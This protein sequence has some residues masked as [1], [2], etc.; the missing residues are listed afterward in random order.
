MKL[1]EKLR[2][3]KVLK[4]NRCRYCL[5]TENLTIDHKIPVIKGGTNDIKN[6]QCLCKRCN[7]IKGQLSQKQIMFLFRWFREIDKCRLTAGKN[8]YG[9][10]L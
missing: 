6:L 9:A 3:K 7:G 2:I 8:L 10:R 4:M 1:K 5:S